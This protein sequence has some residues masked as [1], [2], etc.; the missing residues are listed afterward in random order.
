MYLTLGISVGKLASSPMSPAARSSSVNKPMG[1]PDGLMLVIES[2]FVHPVN[3]PSAAGS[4]APHTSYRL[5]ETS[6]YQ[7]LS[8][9]TV[10]NENLLSCA[11]TPISKVITFGTV[12]LALPV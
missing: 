1:S 2:N 11:S 7:C 9:A 8:S 3:D 6:L 5:G 10:C 12:V 4:T